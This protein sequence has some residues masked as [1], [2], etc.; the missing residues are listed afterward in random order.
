MKYI[1]I[2]LLMLAPAF[3]LGQ[4]ITGKVISQN[5]EPLPG[6][7]V[8]LVGT[9]LQTAT[10]DKGKFSIALVSGSSQLRFTAADMEAVDLNVTD[11]KDILVIMKKRTSKL[12]EI[13]I[14]AYGTNTQR[15]NLGSVTKVSA[16]DIGK[17][18]VSN[19]LEALQGRVPGLTISSTSGLPGS[20]FN[21]Q[22]RGQNTLKASSALI[23]PRDN[24]LFIIDG[25]PFAA[26]NSNI[27]QYNS[28]SAP[29]DGGIYNNSYGGMSPF[30]SLN[31]QDIESIEVLRDADA[32]AIYGSRGGNGVI[33]ITTKKGKAGKTDFNLNLRSG[34]S[35]T[36]K[37]M[38]M[39]NTQQYLAMRREAFANDG[40]EPNAE[41]YDPGYAPD[42]TVFDSTRYT[43]WKKFMLGNTAHNT[44]ASASVSGG[45]TNTQF[46][47]GG[48]FNR[49][50]YIFPGDFA[51]NRANFSSN[52]HHSSTDKRFNIDLT[53]NY[54]YDKNNSS[55]S[56]NVLS[57]FTLEPNSPELLD[58]KGNPVFDYKGVILDGSYAGGNPFSYLKRSYSIT[59]TNLSANLLTSY[60]IVKGLTFRTSLGYNT[61]SANEYSNTPKVTL[62]PNLNPVSSAR[63]G[64]NN[65]SSWIIE[66]QLEYR[67]T[68]GKHALDILAGTTFQRNSSNRTD[69]TGSGYINDAL[70]GSISGAAT[71]TA[72]DA[73]SEYKYN[74]VFGRVSYRYDS[75]YLLNINGRRD[76]SS[77]FGPDKQFG[78]FGSVGAGWIFTEESLI[79]NKIP[80]LSYGKLRASYGITGSDAI[81]NYQYLSRWSPARYPYGGNSGYI[82]VN[83]YNPQLSWASTKKLEI[84]LETGFLQD[85]L[86]LSAAWFRNRTGNQLV[87]T[88]LPDQTGFTSVYENLGAVVQNSGWEILLQASLLRGNG[89]N[90]NSTFNLTIPKNKL[91]AFPDIANSTYSTI[92]FIG[93]SVNSVTGFSY[94]GV[95]PETGLFQFT[96]ANGQLTS[97]PEPASLGKLNDYSIIGNTD[98]KFYGGWLN[99]FSFKG[100]QLDVFTEFKK[101]L[102]M[103]YLAQVYSFLPGQEY[104]L[105]V[106]FLERWH[107]PGQQAEFQRLSSQYN[108]EYTTASN[109]LTSSGVYSDASY[110]RIK[111]ATLSYN[112]PARVVSRLG[113]RGLRV[114]ATAQNLFTITNYK[115]TDPE[116]QN[117]YGVPPLKSIS[118]G[119]NLNL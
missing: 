118:F 58:N 64:V 113:L 71:T 77:R 61:F 3:C 13:Q 84:G 83:L 41:L 51:D 45:N 14:V 12:D 60:E 10:D 23:S 59:S 98:P 57:A 53:A 1:F 29:G 89:F 81:D 70:L 22:V 87:T 96:G 35:F 109:F 86:L 106:S 74:A 93:K 78:N 18:A 114:Y 7:T 48:G 16:D 85:R 56:P 28:V 49:D 2:Y 107:T 119:F 42:L 34:V 46:R 69:V 15:Y 40:L 25:V 62:S 67:K 100:F 79:K 36:G 33:L 50:T 38:P 82:P 68:S 99:S 37:S 19:P 116:T 52:I 117:F 21:V 102:G 97:F 30:N 75:K 105:P 63:F 76:G 5:N 94:A 103:N 11:R 91:I 110:I 104:N 9:R 39:M 6:I 55:G 66:P 72:S 8:S 43:D 24:P 101:Q 31:P 20:A 115:G 80:F 4:N 32:T 54:S 47:I 73:F 65:L 88:Q 26:Q 27:N 112:L 17:Q 108:D 95:N 92:Y 44:N 111:T 90:W